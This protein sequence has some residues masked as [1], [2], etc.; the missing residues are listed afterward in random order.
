MKDERVE[1]VLFLD[2]TSG[3]FYS[4]SPSKGLLAK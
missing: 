4:F 2:P 1:F 3:D